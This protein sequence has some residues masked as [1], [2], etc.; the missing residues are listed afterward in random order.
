MSTK[1][2]VRVAVTG[3]AG[4]IGYALLFRIASGEMLGKDQPVILQLLEVPV[5]GPQKALR[6]VMMELEDCAF[7]LLH[8]MEAHGDPMAA[9]KDTDYALLVG[10]MPRKAGMERAELLSI[11]GQIFIGQGKALNA[12][13]S[14]DVKVLVVG[15]PANTNAWIAMKSAPDLKRENFTAMLRLDHNRALSQLA[16]K[17][18]KPVASIKKLGVWGNHSPTMYADYRFATID[19]ASVKDMINDHAWNKDVFL[20][21]V[22]KRG[23]AIIEAR[24]LSSAASAANAAIDHMRDWALG[25]NGGWVTMGVPSNGEYGI[26]KDVMFGYPVTC[27]GGRYQI[28]EGLPIDEFSQGCIDKTLAELI[29]EQDGVKHLL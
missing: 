6:G 26:P 22:G 14:R 29:G 19:G 25:T 20:P 10:S 11:N 9:F 24:G 4:Q 3:A 5:E 18:G 13:A 8:G 28:V 12:V 27:E 15:N 16:A 17:T 2:P 23:A 7:P 21:T 1:K